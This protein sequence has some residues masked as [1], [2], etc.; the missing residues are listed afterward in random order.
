MMDS[1]LSEFAVGLSAFSIPLF[2]FFA[3]VCDVSLG[4]IRIILVSRSRRSLAT[5]FG[6]IEI[7]IWLAAISQIMLNLT[8]IANYI[9]YAAGFAT[10]TFVGMTIER[11]LAM[12]SLVVRVIVP[13]EAEDLIVYLIA[14]GFDVTRLNAEGAL[15]PVTVIFTVVKT[16]ELPRVLDILRKFQPRAFYTVEDVRTARDPAHAVPQTSMR[17]QLLQPFY[18]FRKSK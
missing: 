11:R 7:L 10:G 5:M 4:T 1:W 6:F 15:E 13:R 8:D 9:A 2:I 3:R 18:W 12:G 14:A 16:K 17:Q